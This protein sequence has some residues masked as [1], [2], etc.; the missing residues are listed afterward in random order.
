MPKQTEEKMDRLSATMP[1][2]VLEGLR[3]LSRQERRPISA[4]LTL[5]VEKYLME[6]EERKLNAS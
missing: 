1:R 2:D 4:Q 3:E 6:L 5:I